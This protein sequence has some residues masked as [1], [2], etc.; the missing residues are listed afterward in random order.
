MHSIY[1]HIVSLHIIGHKNHIVHNTTTYVYAGMCGMFD[2][3]NVFLGTLVHV[4]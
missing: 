4:Y 2:L 3:Y 1:S